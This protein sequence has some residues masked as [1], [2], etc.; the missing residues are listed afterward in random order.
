[1]L[2]PAKVQ[3]ALPA[4]AEAVNAEIGRL[5]AEAQVQDAAKREDALAS[6]QKAKAA[7]AAQQAALCWSMRAMAWC[8]SLSVAAIHATARQSTTEAEI[9]NGLIFLVLDYLSY[10]L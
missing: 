5:R 2:A 1:M 8:A 3:A 4:T 9:F 6:V 10:I 7:Q